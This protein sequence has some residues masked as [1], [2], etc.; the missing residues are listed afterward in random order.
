[1]WKRR[2][3]KDYAK[4]F[5]KKNYWQAFIAVLITLMLTGGAVGSVGSSGIT[6]NLDSISNEF[7][8]SGNVVANDDF[9]FLMQNFYGGSTL[10]R[11]FVYFGIGALIFSTLAIVV[12]M[13]MV[14]SVANVGL[15]KFFL[16]GFKDDVDVK[17]ILFGFNKNDYKP[18]VK[19]QFQTGLS[20]FLWSLLFII[21]GLIK[22]YAYR[23][24]PYLLAEDS[25]LT[26]KQ[27]MSQS[28][29][30]TR[31]HKW[32]IFILDFSFIWWRML[33]IVSFGLASLFV[34][35]Y[36]AAVNAK[37]YNVLASKDSGEYEFLDFNSETYVTKV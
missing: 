22:S 6:A 29:Q 1:M 26:P 27:A 13:I 24:V 30:L 31:G 21:P 8:Q 35:P 2:D 19:A 3:L 11:N 15:A 28:S 7:M 34:A 16:N 33:N 17:T 14:G 37:L 36:I 23:F 9:D 10:A 32:S 20:I 18:I 25:S 5:L 4:S 12:I